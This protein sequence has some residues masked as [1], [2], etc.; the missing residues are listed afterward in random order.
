MEDTHYEQIFLK[1]SY[2]NSII[3]DL[4]EDD[5]KIVANTA[6]VE[7]EKFRLHTMDTYYEHLPA[8]IMLSYV[9]WK[10]LLKW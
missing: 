8:F 4:L 3:L 1:I 2:I 7:T 5:E 9:F 6:L 10:M